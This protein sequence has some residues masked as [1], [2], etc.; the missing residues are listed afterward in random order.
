MA[1]APSFSTSMRSTTEIGI[2][3]RSTRALLVM[4][5]VTQRRPLTSTRVRVSP[6]PRS[7]MFWVP[8]A[9]L[10]LVVTLRNAPPSLAVMLNRMSPIEVRP[11]ASM[12]A[13]SIDR[14]G[15]VPSTS[16]LR[17]MREPVTTTVSSSSS[18]GLSWANATPVPARAVVLRSAKEIA[19]R[20]LLVFKVISLSK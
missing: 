10:V 6:R 14:T 19:S 15:E 12:A 18:E 3:L 20:S 17:G 8:S 11:V 13:R 2:E 9:P 4:P 16:A 7:E 5:A 1:E